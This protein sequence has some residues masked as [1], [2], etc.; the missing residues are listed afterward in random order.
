MTPSTQKAVFSSQAC[1]ATSA[2]PACAKQKSFFQGE[3]KTGH[4]LPSLSI[5]QLG[6]LQNPGLT[7]QCIQ[8]ALTHMA[9]QW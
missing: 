8:A 5:G 1:A 3:N 7:L 6:S 4:G 9:T 2:T